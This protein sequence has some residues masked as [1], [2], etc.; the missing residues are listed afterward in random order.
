MKKIPFRR[1]VIIEIINYFKFNSYLEIGLR[2]GDSVFNHV[3]CKIKYSVD[4]NPD[5]K[6]S[7][8]GTSDSFFSQSKITDIKWDCI[9]IDGWH[10]IDF[11]YRDLINSVRHLTENGVIFLHDI[12][13]TKYEYTLESGDINCQTA[14]KIIPYILKHHPELRVCSIADGNA[15]IG[16]VVKGNRIKTLDVNFNQFYDYN[17]MDKNR[18]LSQNVIDYNDLIGW[19]NN[20]N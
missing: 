6:P 19:I 16:V 17:L 14:W 9:F 15:G 10:V 18:K 5:S 13:P 7:Y 4:I 1:K 2:N 12:L 11:V 20:G 8:C 3:P